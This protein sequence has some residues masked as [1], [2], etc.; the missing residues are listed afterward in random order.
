MTTVRVETLL[1]ASPEAAFDLAADLEEHVRSAGTSGE[2]IVA[3]TAAG[4]PI[5]LGDE[6]TFEAR[7]LGLR[8]RLTSRITAHD[9]PRCLVD[10]TIRSPFRS[11]RHEHLFEPVPIESG[12]GTR[13]IDVLTFS[14]PLGALTEP[15]LARHLERFLRTRNAH[16]K[17]AAESTLSKSIPEP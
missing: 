3:T 9:R 2:R 8:W 17:K 10:E 11:F 14:A 12:E 6:V 1:P 7:H 15:I 13:M 16:L 4:R 5:R